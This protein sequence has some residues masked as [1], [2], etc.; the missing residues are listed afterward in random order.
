[1][2]NGIRE[3]QQNFYQVYHKQVAPKLKD[4]EAKRQK[5]KTKALATSA[6]VFAVIAFIFYFVMCMPASSE[7]FPTGLIFMVVFAGVPAYA[8]F[9]FFQ[10]VFEK[11]V[12]RAIM[13]TLM[14]AF[15][16]FEWL[17]STPIYESDIRMSKLFTRFERMY[18]DDSFAGS[19]QGIPIKISE[20]ILTYTTRDSDN[21]KQTH[22]E[23]KGVLVSIDMLK[24]FTGHTLVKRRAPLNMGPYQEVKLEDPEFGRQFYVSGTDQVEA[25]F[26]LTTAFI[27]R[28]KNVQKAFQANVIE[29]SFLNNQLLLAISVNKDLFSLGSLMKP[30]TDTKQFTLFFNELVTIFEM[31]DVLKLTKH[32]GL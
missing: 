26:L 2:Q 14:S 20:V 29:C 22:T 16:D 21:R 24:K 17:Q 3:F 10:K 31:I 18:V 8:I 11:E 12:K 28:F 32:T 4:F 23:F 9:R 7:S 1:M 15:G 27:E 25:R 30:M 13:P 6:S 19:Y 5:K